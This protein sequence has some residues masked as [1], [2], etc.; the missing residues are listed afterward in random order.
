MNGSRTVEAVAAA[1]K[2]IYRE[3]AASLNAGDLDRWISLWTDDGVQMP[4]GFPTRTGKQSI[5]TAVKGSL[6]LFA[7][8][9]EI[10]PSDEVRVAGDWAFARGNYSATLTPRQGGDVVAIDGK[11]LTIL[12]MQADGTWKIHRD[13]FNS[14]VSP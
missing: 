3:Y 2:Q 5:W 14:N 13:V 6:D 7:F 4:P 1:V 8:D 9:I 11:Y 10:P 12:Q